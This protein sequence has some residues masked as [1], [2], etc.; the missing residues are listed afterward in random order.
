METI[1]QE[2]FD[3]LV[4]S[5]ENDLTTDYL[6][7][8]QFSAALEHAM[9]NSKISWTSLDDDIIEAFKYAICNHFHGG[10]E[11]EFETEDSYIKWKNFNMTAFELVTE[12]QLKEALFKSQMSGGRYRNSDEVRL[13]PNHDSPFVDKTKPYYVLVNGDYGASFDKTK[14]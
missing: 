4:K 14:L 1:S 9:R 13:N 6:Y 11:P 8:T 5:F 7:Y 12:S 3:K 10:C 2:K